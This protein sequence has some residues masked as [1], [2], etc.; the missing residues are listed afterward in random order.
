VTP[1]NSCQLNDGYSME[2]AVAE[3][4]LG[5]I[6]LSGIPDYDMEFTRWFKD[7]R[8]SKSKT[9]PRKP[10][11]KTFQPEK[12]DYFFIPDPDRFELALERKELSVFKQGVQPNGAPRKYKYSLNLKKA[13]NSDLLMH[14]TPLN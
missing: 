3:S 9:P 13:I 12:I 5:L 7:F 14:S 4:G 10:L 1:S 11:K 6:I 2:L 8:K